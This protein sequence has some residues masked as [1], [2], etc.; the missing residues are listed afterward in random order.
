MASEYHLDSNGPADTDM[1][2]LQSECQEGKRILLDKLHIMKLILNQSDY[3]TK[4]H[5]GMEIDMVIKFQEGSSGHSHTLI[6]T[7]W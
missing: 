6:A 3:L 5:K 7:L 2:H 4:F 1:H